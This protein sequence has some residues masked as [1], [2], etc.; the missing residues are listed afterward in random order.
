MAWSGVA[1]V[2]AGFLA[3]A[4]TVGGTWMGTELWYARTQL[5]QVE[6]RVTNASNNAER[7]TRADISAENTNARANSLAADPNCAIDADSPAYLLLRSTAD[8]YRG[9]I[10]ANNESGARKD[11]VR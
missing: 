5:T 10:E 1:L 11:P 7:R 9:R 4:A 3:G 6:S 2:G 8:D